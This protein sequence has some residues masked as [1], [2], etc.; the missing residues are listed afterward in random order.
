[1][2]HSDIKFGTRRLIKQWDEPKAD[3]VYHLQTWRRDFYAMREFLG[4]AMLLCLPK[5]GWW[6][7]DSQGNA[8]WAMRTAD[9]Y[10]MLIEVAE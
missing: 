2:K 3:F 9:H 10:D 8:E 5:K 6:Y 7:T 1:M 4:I